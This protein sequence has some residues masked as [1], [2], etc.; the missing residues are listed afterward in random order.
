MIRTRHLLAGIRGDTA[1]AKSYVRLGVTP[2]PH[3]KDGRDGA[4]AARRVAPS[5]HRIVSKSTTHARAQI[6]ELE[7]SCYWI[8]QLIALVCGLACGV[9]AVTGAPAFIAFG[10]L[11]MILVAGVMRSSAVDDASTERR[12]A[13]AQEGLTASLGTFVVT[14]T[15]AWGRSIS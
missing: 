11:H 3:R 8:R 4:A 2:P 5:P 13:M 1:R 14:W 12:W 15:L 9:T 6:A 7:S 10:S